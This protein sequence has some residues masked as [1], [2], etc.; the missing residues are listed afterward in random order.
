[1]TPPLVPLAARFRFNESLLAT[2]TDGFSPEDWARAPEGGGNNAIW[3]LGHLVA[4]RRFLARRLGLS[5]PEETW[6]DGF[7]MGAK[8]ADT[9]TYPS[10][11]TLVADLRS[12][13]ERI[14]Q[15]CG[16]LG[17][18]QAEEP[19]GS[20]FPDGS[21][22]VAGGAHFLYFHET[23]HLGQIGLLRRIHGHPGFA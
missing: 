16:E 9:S 17:P 13:G 14:E 19:F 12:L 3:I 6:E 20:A 23:Y 8:P 11:E 21:N 2:T 4:S 10:P 1:M 22:T 15:R 7:S 5:I 18:D